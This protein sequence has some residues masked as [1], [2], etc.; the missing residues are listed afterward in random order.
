MNQPCN[1]YEKGWVA[2]HKS[3]WKDGVEFMKEAWSKL[4]GISW[5]ECQQPTVLRLVK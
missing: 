4:T 5:E 1:D 2:G 3:G